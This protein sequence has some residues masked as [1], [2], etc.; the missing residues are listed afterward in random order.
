MVLKT[1]GRGLKDESYKYFS[2]AL[3]PVSSIGKTF[4]FSFLNV[5]RCILDS[6]VH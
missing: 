5:D 3:V 2:V 6:D 4:K 1:K